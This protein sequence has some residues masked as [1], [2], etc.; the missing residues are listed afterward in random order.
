MVIKEVEAL[1]GMTRANIRFYEKEG[2]IAPARSDNGY[3][4]YSEAEVEEL[5]KIK[6]LRVLG[7]SLEDIRAAQSGQKELTELMKQHMDTLEQER[8]KLETAAQV[9]DRLG[10]KGKGYNELDPAPYLAKME[11][12]KVPDTDA[13][14]FQRREF[15]RLFARQFDLM[16][17][18]GLAA[19]A[20][21]LIS[22]AA[23]E[24]YSPGWAVVQ[25]VGFSLLGMLIL[26]AVEPVMLHRWGTTPG[27]FL[28]GMKI[29]DP[30][31]EKLTYQ[32][33][34]RRTWQVMVYGMALYIPVLCLF[35]MFRSS[36][37]L[38]NGEELV[39]ERDSVQTQ[40]GNQFKLFLRF[41]AV[42][43][44]LSVCVDYVQTPAR[45]GLDHR[46]RLTVAQ[47]AEN[48]NDIMRDRWERY[49]DELN[50]DGTPIPGQAHEDLN[51]TY[52]TDGERLTGIRLE[53]DKSG[54]KL[55]VRDLFQEQIGAVDAFV[56]AQKGRSAR[57]AADEL[58]RFIA[59][60][61][62]E[63]WEQEVNGVRASCQYTYAGFLPRPEVSAEEIMSSVAHQ[64]RYHRLEPEKGKTQT[65][66]MVFTLELLDQ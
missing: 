14:S 21:R 6:L 28:L 37:K 63:S 8:K 25:L 19:L 54:E 57:A 15:W 2:L 4:D 53:V 46:G 45:V 20:V 40:S 51:F 66:H 11:G 18:G 49:S 41:A 30:E 59:E 3:R 48:Y 12:E 10:R 39:W 23:V 32:A 64:R 31:G 7:L 1:T 42:G 16:V 52:T 5:R 56:G 65:F 24:F 35:A 36:K 38:D 29:R 34:W 13:V 47:F 43:L 26:L 9:C 50:P 33:A 58:S 60:H 27:K 44:L 22:P 62:F 17:Y 61:P 55:Y